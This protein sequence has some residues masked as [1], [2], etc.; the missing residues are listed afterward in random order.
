[1]AR[2]RVSAQERQTQIIDAAIRCFQRKGFENTTVDDIAAEFGL[3]K[4]SIYWHYPSKKDIL[5]AVYYHL[6]SRL[7]Q[8]YE[9][10]ILSDAPERQ[11]L[12]RVAKIFVDRLLKEHEVYRPLMVLWSAA[13]EGR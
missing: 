5:V 8:G 11:K 4:G 12:I 13:Y 3:S 7:F 6:I 2:K 1:M 9:A 10:V